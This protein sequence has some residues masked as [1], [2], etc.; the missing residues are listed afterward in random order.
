MDKITVISLSFSSIVYELVV[1]GRDTRKIDGWPVQIETVS[2]KT[3]RNVRARLP[4][5][6][7]SS[8]SSSSLGRQSSLGVIG[9]VVE[10]SDGG[11]ASMLSRL[12]TSSE[13]FKSRYNSAYE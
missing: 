1:L 13:T 12:V 2:M 5:L 4:H 10:S 11:M 9:C 7:L 6:Y 3:S 8:P